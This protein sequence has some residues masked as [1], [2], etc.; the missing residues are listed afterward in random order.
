M[1]AQQ[2][3]KAGWTVLCIFLS[4]VMFGALAFVVIAGGFPQW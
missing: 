4:G 1:T 3:H 2:W